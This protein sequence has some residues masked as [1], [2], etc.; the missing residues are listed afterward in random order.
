MQFMSNSAINDLFEATAQATE[1][2]VLDS[3]I[4]NKTMVGADGN[5]AIGIDHERLL[6][7][8]K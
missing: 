5:T 8:L 3:I 2:A 7:L 6:S 4:A 1:E